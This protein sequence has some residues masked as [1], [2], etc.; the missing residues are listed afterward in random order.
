MCGHLYDKNSKAVTSHDVLP[1]MG[2]ALASTE[3][4]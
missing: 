4:K 3:I 2:Y 1:E